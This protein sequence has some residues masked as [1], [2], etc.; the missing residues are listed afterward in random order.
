[1][2]GYA[3]LPSR[4]CMQVA[5][6]RE[7]LIAIDMRSSTRR[8][9]R[10]VMAGRPVRTGKT[11]LYSAPDVDPEQG[12]DRARVTR[13]LSTMVGV[14]IRAQ[15]QQQRR[16]LATTPARNSVCAAPT[17]RPAIIYGWAQ[18]YSRRLRIA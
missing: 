9:G 16:P 6:L 5:G 3:R 10:T 8:W 11:G 13:W 14:G 4:P 1:M 2:I 7:A 15:V 17:P 18:Q 12:L